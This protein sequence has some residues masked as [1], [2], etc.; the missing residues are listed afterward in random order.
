MLTLAGR[1]E[2]S[3]SLRSAERDTATFEEISTSVEDIIR[4]CFGEEWDS[5]GS[6]GGQLIGWMEF[7]RPEY[8]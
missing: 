6:G 7:A 3:I 2:I 8:T 4:D 1:C 5:I